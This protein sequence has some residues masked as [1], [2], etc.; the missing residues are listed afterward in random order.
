MSRSPEYIRVGSINGSH[1]IKGAIKVFSY[2]DPVDAI[3][4]YSP[5]LLKKG[6]V[7]KVVEVVSG[8][9]QGKRLIAHLEG[10]TD[11]N[12]SDELIGFE[13][14]AAK[15]MLPALEPGDHY[16]FQLEGL[17]VKN[18]QGVI[19]GRVDHLIETGANDVMKVKPTDDS[20]DDLE[21]LIPYVD[22]E[23][24]RRVDSSI[25]EIVVQWEADY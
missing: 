14:Y 16:W 3:T 24:V 13:I 1:G 7:E 2:T 17:L 8:Q 15:S 25:G 18:E 23:I 20:V 4:D 11:R 10:I 6:R 22:G 9:K 5:W 12:E 21:R 19:F